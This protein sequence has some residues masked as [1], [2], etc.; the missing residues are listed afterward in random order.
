MLTMIDYQLLSSLLSVCDIITIIIISSS[1]SSNCSSSSSSS[2][3]S[4]ANH[5]A[6]GL[7]EAFVC[8]VCV[9]CLVVY[10]LLISY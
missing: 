7:R 9:Y 1:S 3:S 8:C 2:S 10:V 4:N 6:E 5:D